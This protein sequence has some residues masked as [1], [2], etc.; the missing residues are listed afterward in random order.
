MNYINDKSYREVEKLSNFTKINF[1]KY[2]E[3]KISDSNNQIKFFKIKKIIK[4]NN[5]NSVC[6]IGSGN[7]RLLYALEKNNFLKN[8]IGYEISKNRV[9]FAKKFGQLMQTKKV[10]VKNKDFLKAKFKKKSFDLIVGVDI[11]FNII[12]ANSKKDQKNLL[13]LCFDILKNKG[14]IIFEIMTFEREL[15]I[16]RKMKHF[17]KI[18]KFDKTDPFKKVFIKHE[19]INNDKILIKKTF[20]KK[21]GEISKFSNLIKPIDKNFWKKL[22][23]WNANIFNYWFKPNDTKEKEY[24]VVLRKKNEKL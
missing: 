5:N 22:K 8:G 18:V 19:L 20:L 17:S 12:S 2:C 23:G 1:L 11:I 16:L 3:K 10:K 14:C 4:P 15:K 7:G 21:N 13:N 24:I 9:N 6:E